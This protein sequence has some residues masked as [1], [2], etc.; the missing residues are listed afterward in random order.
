MCGG[1]CCT[2]LAVSGSV[3]GAL[4]YIESTD[5]HVLQLYQK[6]DCPYG[7]SIS[8]A[9]VTHLVSYCVLLQEQLPKAEKLWG[10]TLDSSR[11]SA[12]QNTAAQQAAAAT[13]STDAYKCHD[14]QVQSCQQMQPLQSTTHSFA[15]DFLEEDF[16]APSILEG[17]TWL[18]MEFMDKGC[19]QARALMIE[20]RAIM[21][22]CCAGCNGI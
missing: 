19:L 22:V 9:C 20:F 16:G 13:N 7:S 21:P 14:S 18:V 3:S 8:V 2:D 12:R 5:L 6:M 15:S 1:L 4:S 17:Q 11:P 10:E